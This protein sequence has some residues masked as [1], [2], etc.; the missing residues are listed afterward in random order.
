MVTVKMREKRDET[1]DPYGGGFSAEKGG[2]GRSWSVIK[3]G[4]GGETML[5]KNIGGKPFG[6]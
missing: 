1:G 3:G 5:I 6:D 2:K 4:R